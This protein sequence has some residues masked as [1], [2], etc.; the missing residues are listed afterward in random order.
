MFPLQRVSKNCNIIDFKMA[1]SAGKETVIM[2]I[3]NT[4]SIV[5]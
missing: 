3:A 4:S 2:A 5:F 1:D